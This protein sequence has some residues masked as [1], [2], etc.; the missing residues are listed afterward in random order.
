VTFEVSPEA[1]S[2]E[3]L[4]THNHYLS[5]DSGVV[6]GGAWQYSPDKSLPGRSAA[7]RSV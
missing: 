5:L 3:V 4:C 6:G 1:V 7:R 2:V